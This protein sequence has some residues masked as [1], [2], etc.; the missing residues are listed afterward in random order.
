MVYEYMDHFNDH[1]IDMEI[2]HLSALTRRVIRAYLAVCIKTCAK[3]Y[4]KMI[5]HGNIPSSRHK[6]TTLILIKSLLSHI[7]IYNG[8][9]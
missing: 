6:M 2:D 3:R 4:S 9:W 8:T 7:M 5:A 1:G